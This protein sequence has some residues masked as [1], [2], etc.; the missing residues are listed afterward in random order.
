MQQ[1]LI[2]ATNQPTGSASERACRL[3]GRTFSCGLLLF[4]FSWILDGVSKGIYALSHKPSVDD[5]VYVA[6]S[7]AVYIAFGIL[8]VAG[9]VLMTVADLD[10]NEYLS[11][12]QIRMKIF[13]VA[14][15]AANIIRS[16]L[17]TTFY[18]SELLPVLPFLVLLFRYDQ[19]VGMQK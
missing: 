15:A 7:G 3:E 2:S 6:L 10:A 8:S 11:R 9:L 18:P 19:V 4:G 13:V 5:A 17:N 1:P 16:T 12:N 14:F